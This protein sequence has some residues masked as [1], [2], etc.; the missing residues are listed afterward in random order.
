M[1]F[2]RLRKGCS[3]R[4]IGLRVGHRDRYGG[5]GRILEFIHLSRY[6]GLSHIV[7]VIGSVLGAEYGIQ[8]TM[9]S[10]E[11]SLTDGGVGIQC[12]LEDH[13][14]SVRIKN[15]ETGSDFVISLFFFCGP[16]PDSFPTP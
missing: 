14:V 15:T 16:R 11:P 6:E 10:P 4:Q 8:F 7:Y 1:G 13:L 5:T 3:S 2:C 9:R 12:T